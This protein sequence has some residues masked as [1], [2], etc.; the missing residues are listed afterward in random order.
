[1][2]QPVRLLI[3]L[4]ALVLAGCVTGPPKPDMLSVPD[5][6]EVERR[7]FVPIDPALTIEHPIA[8][9][10]IRACLAVAADRK[11]ELAKCNADKRAIR[12]VQGGPA[13]EQP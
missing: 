5:V 6:V 2:R 10:P 13:D 11:S 8:E 1:M 7:I 9:G 4:T 3:L 12:A